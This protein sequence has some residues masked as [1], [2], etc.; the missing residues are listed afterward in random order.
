MNGNQ[1]NIGKHEDKEKESWIEK[2]LIGSKTLRIEHEF[3]LH[4]A[5]THSITFYQTPQM[6]EFVCSKS[7]FYSES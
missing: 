6:N 1:R 4:S 3:L 2:L 7:I 5:T